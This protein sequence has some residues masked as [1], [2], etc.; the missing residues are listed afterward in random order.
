MPEARQ[1]FPI[2]LQLREDMKTAMKARDQLK[3]DTLR[4]AM[5]AVRNLEVA[6]TDR[7]NE[8]YGQPITEQDIT[9]VLEQEAK[10]RNQSIQAFKQGGRNDLVEKE[11]RELEILQAYLQGSHASDDEIRV[12]VARLIEAQGKEF[13]RVMPL[14]AKELKGKA[15]GARVQQIVRELIQ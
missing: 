13:R 8:E 14:A 9:R 2:E 1:Q 12:V 3:V 5:S 7:K 10:K 15:D 6:R 11:Q 4:M